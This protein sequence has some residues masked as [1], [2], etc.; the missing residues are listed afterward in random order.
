MTDAELV[1]AVA[2][3]IYDNDRGDDAPQPWSWSKWAL[4][5][6]PG[7]E[8]YRRQAHA[9]LAIARPAHFE[10][11]ARIADAA[12]AEMT[13]TAKKHDPESENHSRVMARARQADQIADAIRAATKA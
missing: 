13:S 9:V 7:A 5:D 8:I 11:C 2:E 1:E 10:E 4:Y 3:K 12:T 6:P